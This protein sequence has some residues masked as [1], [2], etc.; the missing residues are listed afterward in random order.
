[1]K[2]WFGVTLLAAAMA[3]GTAAWAQEHGAEPAG[4]FHQPD[5]I[6]WTGVGGEVVHT[7]HGREVRSPRPPPFVGPIINFAILLV[8]GYM[9]VTRSINPSLQAR[10]SSVESEIAEAKR[11]HDE[12]QAMHTEMT[13][14]L[15][16]LDAEIATLKAQFTAAGEAER[17]R[18]VADA[19]ARVERMRA[20]GTATIEQEMKNLREDLRREAIIAATAAAEAT[21]R[22]TIGADD[23]RRLADEYLAGLEAAGTEGARA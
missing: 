3:M 1:M 5:G 19:K 13:A 15:G 4:G 21:V 12:A 22:A 10:R 18:I 20:D 14:K 7:E 16:S 11:L 23:H 17:D 6:N 8:L 9:A 2:R